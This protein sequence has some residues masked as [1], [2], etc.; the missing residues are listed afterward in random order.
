MPRTAEVESDFRRRGRT[1]TSEPVR[2]ESLSEPWRLRGGN[3]QLEVRLAN[4]T[5]EIDAAQ[6][7]RYRV[8]CEEM[9]AK[10]G[11]NADR[12]RRDCDRFDDYCDHLLILDHT[13]G[14]GGGVVIGTYRLLRRSVAERH[15]G[16]YTATEF[17]IA[18]LLAVKGEMLE[19]GRSCVE[20]AYRT[21]A[22][23]QLLWRGIG[24]YS[25]RHRVKIMFGCASLR[26]TDVKSLAPMLSYLH[27]YHLAP[28]ALRVRALPERYVAMDILTP[29]QI[30][31]TRV[32]AELAAQ[33]T[34]ALLPP[35]I[36]G[37]LR[38]GALIGDGAVIDPDFNTTDVCIIVV[39]DRM[40]DKY[41]EAIFGVPRDEMPLASVYSGDLE[42]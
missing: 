40:P 13:R 9:G 4:T 37:Y 29:R 5:D 36:K 41:F 1:M 42:A 25:L 32:T 35:V 10:L 15:D 39:T 12:I 23:I 38:V 28:P 31:P 3:S 8:F 16:F 30:D 18:P 21:R 26:S 19:L 11:A 33:D 24:E 17:D 6:A 27:Y 2:M 34:F 14:T 7:L 20:P 22:T